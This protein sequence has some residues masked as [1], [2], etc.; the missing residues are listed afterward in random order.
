MRAQLGAKI[1][2]LQVI[3]SNIID[4]YET[5]WRNDRKQGY[6]DFLGSSG[7]VDPSFLQGNREEQ[8]QKMASLLPILEQRYIN[9]LKDNFH[10]ILDIIMTMFKE[11]YK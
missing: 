2:R 8:V 9:K 5:H 7:E 10:R 11:R 4:K 3:L 6:P 1:I